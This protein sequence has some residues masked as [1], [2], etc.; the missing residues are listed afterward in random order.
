MRLQLLGAL[1]ERVAAMAA[2]VVAVTGSYVRFPGRIRFAGPAEEH[3]D[4][5]GNCTAH[6]FQQVVNHFGPHE[7]RQRFSQRYFVC[8]TA[9]TWT[10]GAPIFLYLGN[11]AD[12]ELYVNATGLMW[13]SANV[14][15]AKL[16]FVEHRYFGQSVPVDDSR[17]RLSLAYLTA[18][19][20]LADYAM[21][22]KALRED[23]LQ[24]PC[25]PVIGFGGS[26][27]GMLCAWLRISAP[28]AIDAC[29]AASAPVMSFLDLHPPANPNFFPQ[30]VTRDASGDGGS[31]D[32]C[33]TRIHAM[34]PLIL[35]LGQAPSGR[36]QLQQAFRLCSAPSNVD[37]VWEQVIYWVSSAFD[38][39]A[40]GSYP[41]RS[42]YILN[43]RGYLPPYPL[44][45]ACKVIAAAPASAASQL[46]ALREAV[47]IYYNA[48]GEAGDCFN[49]SEGAN[50]E[51]KS[52]AELWDY[53][54][55]SEVFQTGNGRDGVKDMYWNSPWSTPESQESCWNQFRLWPDPS[56]VASRF[57][58]WQIARTASRILFS[59]GELDPWS[60]GGVTRTLSPELPAVMIPEVGHHIDLF[61]SSAADPP[62][63]IE[64][65]ETERR[66][67]RKWVNEAGLELAARCPEPTSEAV[68]PEV[69]NQFV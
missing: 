60:G 29:L 42:S 48:T 15:R 67:I 47:S 59:N 25:S 5:L 63:V 37:D 36:T 1:P 46:D 49:T 3:P 41:Y 50:N 64:A 9:Q 66:W 39:M 62:A 24:S 13:E 65:R 28:W 34:W 12:V 20:A 26:Y 33:S 21:F 44:R 8:N 45:Q 27:G 38:Y 51:S 16:V 43:G 7:M 14:F 58:G 18:D 61:W 23:L 69:A 40:M 56:Y 22:A 68:L 10:P 11:E 4:V 17:K 32:A 2:M 6:S 53:L 54:F 55:C 52:D 31:P 30:I 19:Q 35:K 57:G